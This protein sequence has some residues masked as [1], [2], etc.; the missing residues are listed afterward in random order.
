MTAAARYEQLAPARDA[1]LSRSYEC[2]ELTIPSLFPRAGS[3]ASTIF[4]T[5]FQSI[6]AEGVNN[7]AA[8]FLL[9]L[10]PPGASC[11]KLTLDD[12]ILEELATKAGSTADDVRAEFE[13]A[14]SKVERAVMNRMEQQGVRM[15][16]FECFKVL[17][18]TGNA[19]LQVLDE[20]GLKLHKLN[21]FV[22]KRDSAGDVLE[23]VVKETMDRSALPSR[24]RI[25]VEAHEPPVAG[26]TSEKEVDL[27]TRIIREDGQWRVYQEVCGYTVPGTEGH[28]PLDKSPWLPLRFIAVD[29]E[30]YGR[31]FVEERLGALRSLESLEQS[32]VEGTAI[33][34]KVVFSV[35]ENGLT[36][37]KQLAEAANGGFVDGDVEKD[38][39]TLKVDKAQDFSVCFQLR[40]D[41]KKSLERAFLLL[42][43]IQRDAERVTAEEVRAVVAELETTLGGVYSVFAQEL[44]RPLVVCEMHRMQKAGELP[45]LPDDAVSPQIVTGLDGLGRN[46][47]LARLDALVSGVEQLFGAEAVAEY[48]NV[49]AYITRRGTALGLDTKG[50]VRSDQE[51][52][53]SR[54]AAQQAEMMKAAIAPSISAASEQAR[55]AAPTT[56]QPTKEAV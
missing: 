44:Q 32:M 26:T 3:T 13:A 23:I 38:V 30:D 15:P 7:L 19:L 43:G 25:I 9:G 39:K 35:N 36:Q 40:N 28:Y 47:D 6:G 22:V 55:A 20:G 24:V 49:S 56:D 45:H 5:P 53:K 8:K 33:A 54:Q 17:I 48:I 31:G 27:Y 51:V 14:L 21:R 37:K 4:Y 50:I 1:Y 46:S 34:S 42:S 10:F 29:G 11:F 52:Q 41:I 16:L 18:V 12:F 2:A